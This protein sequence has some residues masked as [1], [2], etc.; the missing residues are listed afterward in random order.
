[1]R[2]IR[3]RLFKGTFAVVSGCLIIATSFEKSQPALLLVCFENTTAISRL[4]GYTDGL[5]CGK[6]QSLSC[7]FPQVEEGF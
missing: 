4:L 5:S 3:G 7:F 2:V 1:M 6:L